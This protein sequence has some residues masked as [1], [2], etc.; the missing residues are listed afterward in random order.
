MVALI[1]S[2]KI[3]AH[4]SDPSDGRF[5]WEKILRN[6]IWKGIQY[7]TTWNHLDDEHLSK[8]DTQTLWTKTRMK[9]FED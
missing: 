3:H 8:I 4:P 6:E 9:I 5:W 1:R 2:P 7:I